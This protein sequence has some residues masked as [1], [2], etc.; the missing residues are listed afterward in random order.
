MYERMGFVR[1]PR[2]DFRPMP[3]ILVMAYQLTLSRSG[4]TREKRR[5]A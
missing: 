4:G 3:G 5:R 1:D 2:F